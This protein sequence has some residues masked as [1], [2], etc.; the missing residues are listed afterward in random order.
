MI[1]AFLYHMKMVS[2]RLKMVI[3]TV[4]IIVSVMTMALTQMKHGC[5]EIGFIQ[6]VMVL[7][8]MR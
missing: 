7:L 5:M 6:L 3:L 1:K 4:P 2:T 8:V